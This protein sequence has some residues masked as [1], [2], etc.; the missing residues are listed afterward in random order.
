MSMQA[1]G[2]CMADPSKSAGS[3][4]AT[5]ACMVGPLVTGP[6]GR[7]GCAAALEGPAT[8]EVPLVP[9]E[10]VPLEREP[11]EPGPLE[12]EPLEPGPLRALSDCLLRLF[13]AFWAL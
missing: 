12:G 7:G 1:S 8:A 11:L 5:E 9:L 13:L 3:M 4:E 2:C 6:A 10:R